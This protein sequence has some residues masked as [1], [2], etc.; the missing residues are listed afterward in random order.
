MQVIDIQAIDPE[1]AEA[2]LAAVNEILCRKLLTD[3]RHAWRGFP[4]HIDGGHF[5][6]HWDR[7]AALLKHP[8]N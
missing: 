8:P 3:L 2:S 5:G 4:V 6:P 7:R 1:V